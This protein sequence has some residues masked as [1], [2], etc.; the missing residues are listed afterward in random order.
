MVFIEITITIA[1]II[2]ITITYNSK[3]IITS[4]RQIK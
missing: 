3:N 1:I 2:T 4:S